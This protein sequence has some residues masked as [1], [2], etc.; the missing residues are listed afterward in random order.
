MTLENFNYRTNP[1]FLRNQFPSDNIY[2]IPSL[3]KAALT[4][5]EQEKLML[6]ALTVLNLITQIIQTAS[7]TS[8]SMII[9]LK[10]YGQSLMNPWNCYHNIK[11][12]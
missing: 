2:G 1:M 8:F 12:S 5:E 6:I 4:G 3:P 9:T 10:S 7:F 11:V